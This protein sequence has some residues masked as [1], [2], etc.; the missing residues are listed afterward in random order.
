MSSMVLIT[1]EWFPWRCWSE[2]GWLS[3]ILICCCVINWTNLWSDN[4]DDSHVALNRTYEEL[5][6]VSILIAH[7]RYSL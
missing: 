6:K 3:C 5:D 4:L 2:I 1:A 7:V